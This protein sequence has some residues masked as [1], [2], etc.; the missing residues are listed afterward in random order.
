MWRP[1]LFKDLAA[2][3]ESAK[4]GGR[5]TPASA[6]TAERACAPSALGPSSSLGA[7][8]SIPTSEARE[9]AGEHI[10]TGIS[11][12]GGAAPCSYPG[13]TGAAYGVGGSF[14]KRHREQ[15]LDDL[16]GQRGED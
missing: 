7:A 6:A 16:L 5:D 10:S 15:M 3:A 9:E 12:A 2:L 11:C 1:G 14:C 13:C 8:P 4:R